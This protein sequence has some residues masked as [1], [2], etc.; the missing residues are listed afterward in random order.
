MKNSKKRIKQPGMSRQAW[1]T[2]AEIKDAQ[3][4]KIDTKSVYR[5]L[6]CLGFSLRVNGTH[7]HWRHEKGYGL[8]LVFQQRDQGI[9]GYALKQVRTL[10]NQIEEKEGE[11]IQTVKEKFT[12]SEVAQF[13]DDDLLKQQALPKFNKLDLSGLDQRQRDKAISDAFNVLAEVTSKNVYT[14]NSMLKS[15]QDL[16]LELTVKIDG[17]QAQSQ[18]PEVSTPLTLVGSKPAKEP[19][20]VK[21]K[22]SPEERARRMQEGREKGRQA[23][24]AKSVEKIKNVQNT[25]PTHAKDPIFIAGAARM[26]LTV[27]EKHFKEGRV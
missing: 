21:I 2:L 10:I 11:M 14:Q 26:S 23:L 15:I 1:K 27:V 25:Y 24:I 6:E 7:M 22:L 4:E 18:T 5:L 3:A 8:G 17:L 12:P 19:K 16:L 9:W 20:P 13:K